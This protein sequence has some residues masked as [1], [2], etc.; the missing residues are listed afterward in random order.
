D[1]EGET[2]NTLTKEYQRRKMV[3]KYPGVKNWLAEAERRQKLQSVL[4]QHVPSLKEF[5]ERLVKSD[6]T[7]E[8]LL[9]LAAWCCDQGLRAE[10]EDCLQAV[11]LHQPDSPEATQ[12]KQKLVVLAEGKAPT[13]DVLRGTLP[14]PGPKNFTDASVIRTAAPGRQY[15]FVKCQMNLRD[16]AII[17]VSPETLTVKAEQPLTFLGV[18]SLI[19]AQAKPQGFNRSNRNLLKTN[20]VWESVQVHQE[21]NV[22]LVKFNNTERPQAVR[23][24]NGDVESPKMV[25]DKTGFQVQLPPGTKSLPVTL[26]FEVPEWQAWCE[27]RYQQEPPVRFLTGLDRRAGQVKD[28]KDLLLD[29]ATPMGY[30]MAVLQQLAVD[31]RSLYKSDWKEPLM[32]LLQQS[33]KEATPLIRSLLRQVGRPWSSVDARFFRRQSPQPHL[34]PIEEKYER[35]RGYS[36]KMPKSSRISERIVLS[37][38]EGTVSLTWQKLEASKYRVD[39]DLYD[40]SSCQQLFHEGEY[41]T[42]KQPGGHTSHISHRSDFPLNSRVWVISLWKE[43]QLLEREIRAPDEQLTPVV[44]DA[45][46]IYLGNRPAPS[47]GDRLIRLIGR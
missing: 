10:A 4:Y 2:I 17:D 47:N 30:R 31:S 45:I 22:W 16:L 43:G 37:Y 46:P 25:S 21:D 19:P 11:R 3:E 33:D 1:P 44:A 14:S 34:Q 42:L 40:P 8:S 13:L 5:D 29:P 15:L 26:M 36:A 6:K 27:F 39:L 32:K 20:Q 23:G 7:P 41:F 38:A 9:A 35:K 24:T 12:L 28:F 18:T